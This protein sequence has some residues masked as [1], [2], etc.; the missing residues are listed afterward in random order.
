[1]HFKNA[2]AYAVD[3]TQPA[4]VP[5]IFGYRTAELIANPTLS[6]GVPADTSRSS[7]S[8]PYL[9]HQ[10]QILPAMVF[11]VGP[12]E[13]LSMSIR[14]NADGP[15]R[16]SSVRCPRWHTWKARRQPDWSL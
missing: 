14:A 16:R 15:L 5:T 9:A 7:S 3:L 13:V 10:F 8:S 11:S 4:P 1:M 2:M 6:P 12:W